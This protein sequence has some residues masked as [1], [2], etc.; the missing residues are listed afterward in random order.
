VL[1]A[2]ALVACSG[3]SVASDVL[4][5]RQA[6]ARR[7]ETFDE[8]SV[9]LPALALGAPDAKERAISALERAAQHFPPN[10]GGEELEALRQAVDALPGPDPAAAP[11][12]LR[13]GPA[14]GLALGG[15]AEWER[16]RDAETSQRTAGAIASARVAAVILACLILSLALLGATGITPRLRRGLAALEAGARRFSAGDLSTRIA[17]PGRDEL[18]SVGQAFDAMAERLAGLLSARDH[19]EAVMRDRTAELERAQREAA[20]RVEQLETVRI[21]LDASD[22]LVAADRLARGLTHELNNPLAILLADIEF[23]SEELQVVEG[24]TSGSLD[25]VRTA[26]DEARQAGRRIALIVRELMS[27]SRDRAAGD[28]DL[29]DLVQ[30]LDHAARLAGPEIR[31]HG[32]FVTDLPPGPILV[33]GSQ[34]RLGQAFL[35]L[36]LGA[37]SA[38]AAR[39]PTRGTVSLALRAEPSGAAVEI[40]DDGEPIPAELR[41]HLFDPFYVAT[42]GFTWGGARLRGAGLGLASCARIVEAAGGRVEVESSEAAGTVFRIWLPAPTPQARVALSRQAASPGAKRRRLLVVVGDPFECAAAYRT[43]AKA[44]DVAPHTSV[45]S[46][47]A[48]L[49]AGGRYDLI[50]CDPASA[51]GLTEALAAD[52]SPQVEALVQMGGGGVGT[53]GDPAAPPWLGRPISLEQVGAL[54]ARRDGR[55]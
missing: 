9:T 11:S 46:A 25:E 43:L 39:A 8:L 55:A 45:S 37:A 20:E 48:A 33:Q 53:D 49:R 12:A 21:E 19:A 5:S 44:F 40:S 26:L 6:A 18:A 38:A 23:A 32:A 47:L 27:Y 36:L 10:G 24:G 3:A 31:Q 30:T 42:P 16:R 14:L 7:A 1:V 29:A 13:A 41:A 35:E 52:G 2:L 50:L 51:A 4:A 54:L 22:R 28:R 34:A 17:L 15:L